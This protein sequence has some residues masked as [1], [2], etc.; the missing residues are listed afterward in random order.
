MP[1]RFGLFTFDASSQ[2]LLRNGL[3]VP[4][5]PQ[6]ARALALL[7]SK[8]NQLVSRHELRQAIWGTETHVD[9]ERGLAY[10][11]SQ[12]RAALD[13]SAANPRFVQT[14]PRQGYKFICPLASVPPPPR[15]TRRQIALAASATVATGLLAYTLRPARPTILA[16]SIFDNETGLPALDSWVHALPDAVLAALNADAP[17]LAL[18]GNAAPLR[19]PRNIRNLKALAQELHADYLLLGQ[20]QNQS[21]G[22][23]FITHLIRLPGETHLKANRI[24]GQPSDLPSLEAAILAEY[25]RAVRQHVLKLPPIS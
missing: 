14:L 5:E 7:L 11:L 22:F 21:P 13:D 17:Q 23:R 4:L 12:I 1:V 18:I 10:V 3:P 25:R 6:P 20:L 24:L 2:Q 16:V 9:F 19:R 15:F 8:P